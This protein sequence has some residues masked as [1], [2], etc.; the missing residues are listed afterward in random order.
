MWGVSGAGPGT[1]TEGW[2]IMGTGPAQGC[3]LGEPGSL[4]A[5]LVDE[6]PA[7][8]RSAAIVHPAARVGRR[9]GEAGIFVGLRGGARPRFYR[10][11]FFAP[12]RRITLDMLRPRH[13]EGLLLRACV[14]AR[15]RFVVDN[16][17][18]T[19]AERQVYI[20]AAREAGFRVIGY[21]F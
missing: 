20:R 13:R 9:S 17:N 5:C 10:Q 15:Q 4:V 1:R 16:T 8:P 7:S 19:R 12:P 21:Y 3:G 2:T 11:R 14:A 6:T 18:P